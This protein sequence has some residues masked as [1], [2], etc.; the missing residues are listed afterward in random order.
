MTEST[1]TN[2]AL[3]LAPDA[4]RGLA[5]LLEIVALEVHRQSEAL[6]AESRRHAELRLHE[7]EKSAAQIAAQAIA[8]GELEGEREARRRMALAEVETR[9]ELLRIRES[10]IDRAVE[11]AARRLAEL[12][13]GPASV[14]LL[15]AAVRTAASAL[16]EARVR[17]CARARQRA[18]L[19]LKL[20]DDVVWDAAEPQEAGVW[21]FSLDRRRMVDMT[22]GGI[23]RRRRAQ[24]RRAAAAALFGT[25]S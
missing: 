23:L 1:S 18:E 20:G 4:E 14:P 3:A 16:G 21:V 13:E 7:A 8:S 15:V 17:V 9:R 2:A 11:L 12:A 25:G 6:L 19:E 22:V 24:A 10:Q 5:P